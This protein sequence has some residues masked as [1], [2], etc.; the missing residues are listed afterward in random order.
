M[1]RIP[2]GCQPARTRTLLVPPVEIREFP[3]VA[4]ASKELQD[5]TR[6]KWKD[7]FG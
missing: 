2:Q 7:L 1:D 4:E 6:A 3:A 5:K